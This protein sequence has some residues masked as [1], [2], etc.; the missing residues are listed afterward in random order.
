MAD[1][2]HGDAARGAR[3]NSAIKYSLK[4]N[5]KEKCIIVVMSEDKVK[6]DMIKICSKRNLQGN[7][8]WIYCLDYST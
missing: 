2:E 8:Y 4:E 6:S 1:S 5:I 7:I 3:F